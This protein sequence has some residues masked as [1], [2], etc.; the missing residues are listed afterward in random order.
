[1]AR[2]SSTMIDL[3]MTAPKFNLPN[4]VTGNNQSLKELAGKGGTLVMF[5]CN[6]C[7]FVVHV[8][9]ELVNIGN[10]YKDSGIS[11]IAISSNSMI[12]HPQDGPDHMKQLTS[13]KAFPFPYLFDET[14]DVAKAYDAA[15]TPDFYLY[16]SELKCVYRGQMDDSRPGNDAPIDGHD[17]RLAFDQLIND[18]AISPEQ[19]PSIGCNI[20]WHQ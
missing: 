9:D 16:D 12:S 8:M 15:C 10:D 7:P 6:H 18:E 20:K 11:I 4:V 2:T 17:L 13:E 14:Q 5:I 1:M 3:G 19:K